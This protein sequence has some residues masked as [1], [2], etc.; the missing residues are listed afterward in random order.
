MGYIGPVSSVVT[1]NGGV[2]SSLPT[3]S[4]NQTIVTKYI[5]NQA[6]GTVIHTT[7]AGKTFYCLGMTMILNGAASHCGVSVDGTQVL[8][9]Q[10]D[11]GVTN[12]VLQGGIL[13]SCPAT[14][15]ITLTSGS[16]ATINMWGYEQWTF[17]YSVKLII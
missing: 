10:L 17:L 1:I 15:Q 5:Y 6:T 12:V 14:K 16:N 8:K 7:T 11:A 13:F 2:T 4:L 9:T 3:P